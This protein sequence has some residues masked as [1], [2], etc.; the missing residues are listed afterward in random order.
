MSILITKPT[1]LVSSTSGCA[2]LPWEESCILVSNSSVIVGF[3]LI[4]VLPPIELPV[5][6]RLSILFFGAE[7]TTGAS[8]VP[9]LPVPTPVVVDGVVV[10]E[11]P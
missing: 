5:A 6:S 11:C 4:A 7:R 8:T 3:S 9:I 1:S 10:V 2:V